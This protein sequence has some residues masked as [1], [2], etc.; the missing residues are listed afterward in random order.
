MTPIERLQAKHNAVVDALAKARDRR[1]K[2]LDALLRAEARY[3]SAVKAVGR[4]G[5][6]LDKARDDEAQRNAEGERS[7]EVPDLAQVLLAG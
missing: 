6:R 4:S 1:D 5:K 7:D 3:R 2:A